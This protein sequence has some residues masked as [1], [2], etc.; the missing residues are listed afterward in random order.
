MNG[1]LELKNSTL[2]IIIIGLFLCNGCKEK[3]LKEMINTSTEAKTNIRF[4]TKTDGYKEKASFNRL[5]TDK[6]EITSTQ[7]QMEGPAWENENVAFRNYF[8]ARNGIDIYGKRTAEMVLDSVGIDENY[9]ELQD[10]GMD[11][12]KVGNSL[13][14]GA[15]GMIIGDSLYR[16]GVGAEG[17]FRIIEEG[18]KSS[19]LEFIFRNWKVLDRNYNISHIIR[20]NSGTHYY[21]GNIKVEDLKGD[22][23][24][25]TGIVDHGVGITEFKTDKYTIISTHGNQDV[26]GE[27][28]GMAI[29]VA[30]DNFAK[31]D[32]ASNYDGAVDKTHLVH[33]NGKD[34]TYK[35]FVGWELQDDQFKSKDLFEEM[36]NQ[37]LSK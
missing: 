31:T 21:E 2:V 13:G 19:T 22:E 28:L 8:D 3:P 11:I 25:V 4:A 35:F 36:V 24:L 6:T 29:A 26:E 34:L 10:W 1:I 9:H 18:P 16:V 30:N 32:E 23:T 37:E 20:I 14:A 33:L 7:F 5:T 27:R 12:L 15:I 17:S